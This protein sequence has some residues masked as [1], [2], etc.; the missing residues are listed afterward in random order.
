MIYHQ[1]MIFLYRPFI[2]ESDDVAL[3]ASQTC[4]NSAREI[5]R[6]L[7]LYRRH[8][9]LSRINMHAV[10]VT[11]TAGIVHAYDSCVFSGNRGKIAEQNLLECINALG[12][13]GQSFNSAVRGIE[14]I[15]SRRRM[16]RAQNFVQIGT[17]R[18]RGPFSQTGRPQLNGRKASMQRATEVT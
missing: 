8:Y 16:W 2:S 1:T 4:S 12:E 9:A 15:T 3:P 11:M 10:A 7:G 5:C 14:V 17:K 13:M 18:H 6:L